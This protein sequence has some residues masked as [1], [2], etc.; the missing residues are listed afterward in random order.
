MAIVLVVFLGVNYVL[1][2]IWT[3]WN[4]RNTTYGYYEE[5]KNTVETLF[6]GAST[7]SVG[8]IPMQLYEDYGISS[9]NAG[10][11]SQ[12][13][14]ASYYLAEEF[15]RL[16]PETL[17]TIILDASILR[18][19]PLESM[20]KKVLDSIRWYSPVKFR[21]AWDLS[22][23]DSDFWSNLIPLLS[24]HD[25]WEELTT[26]D[27]Q[28]YSYNLATYTRGYYFITESRLDRS[29]DYTEIALPNSVLQDD[30]EADFNEESLIYFSKLVEFC[31]SHNIH[32]TILKT[33]QDDW[34]DADHNAAAT[35]AASVNLEFYDFNY[36]PL[37]TKI[38]Y[39]GAFDRWD[40]K[41]LNYYGASELTDWLGW[42]L[43][44]TCGNRDV[45][46]DAA[47]AF[48]EEELT[49]YHRQ[50]V[51]IELEQ[52]TDPAEYLAYLADEDGYAVFLTAKE[53]ASVSLTDEQRETFADLGLTKLSDLSSD[54]AYLAVLDNGRIMERTMTMEE[55]DIGEDSDEAA[56]TTDEE[57]AGLTADTD[58]TDEAEEN[59]AD[60]LSL[61]GNLIGGVSYAITSGMSDASIQ[62]DGEEYSR[63]GRGLNI[64]VYDKKLQIIVDRTS[65]DTYASPEREEP[66]N[67]ETLQK[68]LKAG[69]EE[70]LS[71][72]L[73]DLYLYDQ[74]R[75]E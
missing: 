69:K 27:F 20:Y 49:D 57:E 33:P 47:Y 36:E 6:L 13:L 64:V 60:V 16:N 25:R 11:E 39:N 21:F 44:E 67:E 62:I 40:E 52:I 15:Y 32:L 17:D 70:T 14:M 75:Q 2:P 41:H 31:N 45:R 10:T 38:G 72:Q 5:P 58:E 1:Q 12:P 53:D 19:V 42:Y 30:E 73:L 22:D 46:G 56:D 48:L 34:T 50:T 59:N 29:D 18:D 71:G 8:I 43:T 9:Y 55:A 4:M 74:L 24:Y 23:G 63:W 61:E 28:K 66:V 3:D 7:F 68:A 26:E 35:L 65:F 37:L 51:S 54:T